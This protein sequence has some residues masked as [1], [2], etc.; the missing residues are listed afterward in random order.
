[1]TH[2]YLTKDCRQKIFT[3]EGSEGVSRLSEAQKGKRKTSKNSIKVRS[4]SSTSKHGLMTKV[5]RQQTVMAKTSPNSRQVNVSKKMD[6]LNSQMALIG[7]I[8]QSGCT[9]NLSTGRT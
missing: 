5:Y 9:S 4:E 2:H 3:D 6:Q 8:N 7:L 1:M